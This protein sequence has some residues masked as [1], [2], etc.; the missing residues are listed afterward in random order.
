MLKEYFKYYDVPFDERFIAVQSNAEIDQ[1]KEQLRWACSPLN[2]PR[3]PARAP[4]N[5]DARP[6]TYATTC[7]FRPSVSSTLELPD[8]DCK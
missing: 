7:D 5:C 4:S 1:V 6:C 8:T 3:A 2:H